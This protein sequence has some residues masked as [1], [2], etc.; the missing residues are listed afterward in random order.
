M[1]KSDMWIA[2]AASLGVGAATFYAMSKSEQ[3]LN[4]AMESVTP[5][6]SDLTSTTGSKTGGTNG[7]SNGMNAAGGNQQQ[8]SNHPSTQTQTLGP[9]G[10]S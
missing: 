4:K 6:L 9:F 5:I 1:K 7:M 3:P 2:A 10:M 8:Q